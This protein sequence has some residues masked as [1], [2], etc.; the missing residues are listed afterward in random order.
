MNVLNVTQCLLPLAMGLEG[1]GLGKRRTPRKKGEM[2]I[3]PESIE[4]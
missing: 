2:L 1:K 3:V 4:N